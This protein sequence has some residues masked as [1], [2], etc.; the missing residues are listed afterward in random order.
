MN[1]SNCPDCGTDVGHP[2]RNECDIERCSIC[3][4][5]RITCDCK[6][7][8]PLQSIWTGEF[9]MPKQQAEVNDCQIS[10]ESC[11][12]KLHDGSQ[13]L[14]STIRVQSIC[15]AEPL[16]CSDNVDKRIR[17]MGGKPV[18]GWSVTHDLFCDTWVNH[19]VWESPDGELVDVTPVFESATN[20]YAV[21]GWNE[22][23][24]FVRDDEATFVERG[25]PTKYVSTLPNPLV[26]EACKI[27]ERADVFLMAGDL[28]K[29]EYWTQKAN[30]K[31]R[32]A[33][34]NGGFDCPK[35]LDVAELINMG[36][37]IERSVE[38]PTRTLKA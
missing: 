25:R 5:Q 28:A 14:V 38:P 9:P 13:P 11:Q 35:S 21:I 12:K 18:F 34:I 8:D 36:K 16:M 37:L 19:C 6:S 3:G 23:T 15:G 26:H 33:G 30:N 1:T 24:E 32:Q 7:H 10:N 27:M 29:C 17:A 22:T 4:Q 2:H 20:N 31:M